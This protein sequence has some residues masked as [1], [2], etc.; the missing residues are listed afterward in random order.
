ML[1]KE[2]TNAPIHTALVVLLLCAPLHQVVWINTKPWV[3]ES[4]PDS[5]RWAGFPTER[6][7][8]A[9]KVR[10]KGGM[11][12]SPHELCVWQPTHTPP[13]LLVC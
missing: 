7:Y 5:D 8:L 2:A 6:E 3:G 1:S 13:Q 9:N 11:F 12:P 4:D 10:K